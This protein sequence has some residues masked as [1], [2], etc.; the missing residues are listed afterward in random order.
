MLA[1]Y[2]GKYVEFANE[3]RTHPHMEDILYDKWEEANRVLKV[4]EPQSMKT[5]IVA[6]NLF[7]LERLELELE[8]KAKKKKMCRVP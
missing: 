1:K 5:E 6:Q 4:H 3:L 2:R 7:W 8:S